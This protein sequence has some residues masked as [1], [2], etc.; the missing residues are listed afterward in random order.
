L[1][2]DL[3]DLEAALY[4]DVDRPGRSSS[5][6]V[7]SGSCS[8]LVKLLGLNRDLYVAQDTWS[9]FETMLRTLKKYNLGYHLTPGGDRRVHI[10]I[11]R[12]STN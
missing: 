2:G 9:G 4:G 10:F 1:A 8:A 11:S 6:V 7:G 12:N 5:R 3:G